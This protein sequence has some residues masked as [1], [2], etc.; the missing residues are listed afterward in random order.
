MAD[1]CACSFTTSLIVLELLRDLHSRLAT[2]SVLRQKLF[3][4]TPCEPVD[5]FGLTESD[6]K[7]LQKASGYSLSGK[8]LIDHVY[9]VPELRR[10]CGEM[11]AANKRRVQQTTSVNFSRMVE[12][13]LLLGVDTLPFTAA[14]S[15]PPTPPARKY[16]PKFAAYE[17]PAARTESLKANAPSKSGGRTRRNGKKAA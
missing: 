5:R 13:L 2:D 4:L 8:A 9:R 1:R 14:T 7:T 16:D 12:A 17:T 15:S 6:Y 11:F 3:S 10:R